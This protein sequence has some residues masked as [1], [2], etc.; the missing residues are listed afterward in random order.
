[1][2]WACVCIGCCGCCGRGWGGLK[3]P[4]YGMG[5][6]GGVYNKLEWVSECGRMVVIYG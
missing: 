5:V 3:K 2:R 6:V 1:M 4:P